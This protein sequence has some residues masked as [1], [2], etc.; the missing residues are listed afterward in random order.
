LSVGPPPSDAAE[1]KPTWREHGVAQALCLVFL[2]WAYRLP[3]ADLRVPFAYS[4]D[5]LFTLVLTKSG[6]DAGSYFENDWLGA[7][8][9]LEMYDHP[10]GGGLHFALLKLLTLLTRSAALSINVYFLLGFQLTTL[11]SLAV[12]R[13]LGLGRSAALT[14]AL[15][16][17]FLPYHFVRGEGHLFLAGYYVVPLALLVLFWCRTGK[18]VLTPRPERRTLAALGML[19]LVASANVYY[20]FFTAV[21]L[22]I[23]GAFVGFRVRRLR[24]V[25]TSVVLCLVL[26]LAFSANILPNLLHFAEHGRNRGGAD[27]QQVESEIHGLRP[28]ALVMPMPEHRLRLFRDARLAYD[29]RR[30]G[31]ENAA[32]ALGLIGSFGFLGLLA[33][34][35]RNK[36]N[37]LSRF[38][39]E[40]NLVLLLLGSTGA[41]GALFAAFVTPLFRAYARVS[42]FIG[43]LALSM[44][45]RCFARITPALSARI[46][47]RHT[48]AIAWAVL[49]A[50][51]LMDQTSPRLVPDHAAL[52]RV[53]WDD[54]RFVR[55]LEAVLPEQPLFVLPYL[56]FPESSAAIASNDLLR[57]YMHT[58]RLHFSAGA[59]NG[60]YAARWQEAVSEMPAEALVRTVALA[61]FGA[62]YVDRRGITDGGKLE[63]ELTTR[64]GVPLTND[65]GDLAVYPLARE[66]DELVRS[67]A[68]AD[69]ARVL[70][71]VVPEWHGFYD[72][73]Q[74]HD[75]RWRWSS[76]SGSIRLLNPAREAQRVR[77]KF[78]A[79][80]AGTSTLL[81][82]SRGLVE[83][84]LQLTATS[85]DFNQTVTVPPG[86]STLSFV[87]TGEPVTSGSRLLSFAFRNFTLEMLE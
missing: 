22:L 51:G 24:P 13:R 34:L 35:F 85:Q 16:Y 3:S 43:F 36:R 69:R 71:R 19:V 60:T 4:G 72:Q 6:I 81:L 39:A 86:V 41:F 79:Y 42:V 62:I 20:A 23:Q 14:V 8:F 28:G 80:S 56:A 57:G 30:H 70:E 32:A 18:L 49:I 54:R 7:P 50:L 1:E 45:V 12:A 26:T 38:L 9:G 47:F 66:L 10:V 76:G 2:V 31:L 75:D 11:T 65:A 59:M 82:Q 15:L 64:L 68:W 44:A 67:P 29:Q 53:Y 74:V 77:V 5:A 84:D 78:Q 61:G 46:G 33:E 48:A 17:A 55:R 21:L 27:R 40:S 63:S 25:A 73:E 37:E 87:A 83:K 58:R 52:A